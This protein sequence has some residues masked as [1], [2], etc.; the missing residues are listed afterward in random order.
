MARLKD[1]RPRVSIRMTNDAYAKLLIIGDGKPVTGLE[2]ILEEAIANK[3]D[4][5]VLHTTVNTQL[6]KREIPITAGTVFTVNKSRWPNAINLSADLRKRVAE[7]DIEYDERL[8]RH[9]LLI[10]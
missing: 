10:P 5:Y 2:R 3:R 6:L 8:K 7:S 9:G 1:I 4:E